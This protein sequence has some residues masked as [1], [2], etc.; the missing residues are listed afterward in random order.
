MLQNNHA[1]FKY[2]DN[3]KEQYI[4]FPFDVFMQSST[5]HATY[6]SMQYF[7]S[8]KFIECCIKHYTYISSCPK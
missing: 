8:N 1:L 6:D 7:I 3:H 2:I 4:L 5:L